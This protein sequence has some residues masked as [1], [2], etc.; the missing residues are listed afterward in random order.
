MS[1]GASNHAEHERQQDDYYATHPDVLK[2]FLKKLKQDKIE[3]AP[4]IWENACGAGHLSQVLKD[5]GYEVLSTDSVDR[6][7]SELDFTHDFLQNTITF[8]GDILTNPPYKFAID[9]VKKSLEAIQEGNK[10]IMFLRVNFL[11]SKTRFKFY[12]KFPPKYIYAHSERQ[13]CAMNGDFEKYKDT[14]VF[15]VWLIWEKG[16]TDEPIFRWI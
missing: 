7:Y 13:K 16:C 12:E 6:G 1:L 15:Y 2:V 3:L 8:E 10:V 14:A 5:E 11:E 9:F 4:N